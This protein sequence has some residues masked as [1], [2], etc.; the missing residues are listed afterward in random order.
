MRHTNTKIYADTETYHYFNKNPKNRN[1]TDCVFRAIS[2]AMDIDY[3]ECVYSMIE[4]FLTNGY[5]PDDKMGIEKF[6]KANGWVKHNQ[7]RY[8]DGKRYRGRDF[9]KE[10]RKI[11]CIALIGSG[12]VTCIKNGKIW[13]TYDCGSHCIG[14]YWTKGE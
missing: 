3:T 4:M 13:D 10:N 2:T 8:S 7:P 11:T 6:L 5:M 12:H 1:T 9:C 14:N